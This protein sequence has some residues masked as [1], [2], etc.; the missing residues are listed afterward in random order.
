[1]LKSSNIESIYSNFATIFIGKNKEQ[2][3][4]HKEDDKNH[5]LHWVRF[6]EIIIC[7]M[8]NDSTYFCTILTSYNDVISSKTKLELFDNISNNQY[9]MNDLKNNLKE[10]LVMTFISNGNSLDFP[11]IKNLID[12][13]YFK[14]FTK[15]QFDEILN[16]LTE[17]KIDNKKKKIYS[18]KDSSLKYLD[19]NFYFSPTVKSKAELYINDF[20]KDIFKLFNSYY[21]KP[22][23]LTCNLDNK[24]FE[25][26]LLN[27]EN[28]DLLLKIVNTLLPKLD[29]DLEID[30]TFIKFIKEAKE[31]F[32]PVILNY[33]T[34]LGIINSK[35]FIQ[36]KL[37]NKNIFT[38]IYDILN[39]ALKN[40]KNNEIF[41]NDLSE[42]VLNT[43]NQLN[44]Y[45]KIYTDIKGDLNKLD[46]F[47]K[48][49]DYKVDDKNIIEKNNDKI[50]GEENNLTKK[51]S[52]KLKEKY[53]NLIKQ[54]R[55][56]FME[57]NKDNKGITEFIESISNKNI[58]EEKDENKIICLFCRNEIH[59]DSFEEPYGKMGY[60]YKDYFYKNSFKSSI[61]NE[62]NK[63]ATKDNEEKNKIYSEI[64]II[65]ERDIS[66]RILS[67]GHYFHFKCFEESESGYIR[68]PICEKIGNILIPP[69]TNF[70]SKEQ[71]LNPFK[72]DSILNKKEELKILDTNKDNHLFKEVNT[73]FLSSIIDR[74]LPELSEDEDLIDFEEIEKELF[75]NFEYYLNY[76]G[77]IFYSESTIFLSESK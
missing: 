68:C 16:D 48:N 12:D 51:K 73:I 29:K 3:N 46:D 66:I 41:D 35:N 63:I 75:V 36:F 38:E 8:K 59:L 77:Y 19:M 62:F 5:I 7:I 65:K 28:L 6:F 61:R 56:N 24:V 50:K 25:N 74:D 40:N 10:K 22:S 26:I 27:K 32:L 33:I 23:I 20:K 39:T 4:E 69:L 18:L 44:K 30:N 9:L 15:K 58:N 71:N 21:F 55:N 34:M 70:Y 47:D 13:Y 2:N 60:I 42:N 54:K 14:L 43:I 72:L 76:V 52:N 1:M 11:E 45:E 37:D 31:A 64:K 57:N 67:C 49:I 53:K 17:N